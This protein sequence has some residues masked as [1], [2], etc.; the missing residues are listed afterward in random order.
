MPRKKFA[1]FVISDLRHKG[2]PAAELRHPDYRI[3]SGTSRHDLRILG[4]GKQFPESRLID[5]VHASL[6]NIRLENPFVVDFCQKIDQR[7]AKTQDFFH[8]EPL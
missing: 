5:R 3:A 6:R 4:P 7:G 2:S 8:R 1:E